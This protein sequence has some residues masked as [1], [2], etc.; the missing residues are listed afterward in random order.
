MKTKRVTLEYSVGSV[1]IVVP[2]DR[3]G[4]W[5]AAGAHW[6]GWRDRRS[7][8]EVGDEH[9]THA[10]RRWERRHQ[11]IETQALST[12][13]RLLKELDT[14]IAVVALR[15]GHEPGESVRGPSDA[16]LQKA[17]GRDRAAWAEQ[18][19]AASAA[20]RARSERAG[21]TA[22]A[23]EQLARL[24]R[25]RESL[26]DEVELIRDQWARAFEQYGARYTTSRY[27]GRRFQ[28]PTIP[29]VP[30]YT[31]ADSGIGVAPDRTPQKETR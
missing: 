1:V 30:G 24:R 28:M 19:R 15:A 11:I 14:E 23:K 26:A 7:T 25:E 17:T 20:A 2:D 9:Q 5:T 31:R 13:K 18:S 29:A 10:L 8:I 6:N 16:D 4:F 12:A 27:R 21:R 22:A 3:L